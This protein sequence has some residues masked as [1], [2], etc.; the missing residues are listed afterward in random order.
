MPRE[1][2][3]R[4]LLALMLF[5]NSRRVA[6]FSTSGELLTLEQQ[7]RSLWITDDVDRA[8]AILASASERGPYVVQ[9]ALAESHALA[10]S[11][12]AT[13]WSRIV[14]LYDELLTLSPSPVAWFNRAIAVGMCDGPEAGLMLLDEL[15]KDLDGFRLVPAARADLLRRAGRMTEAIAQYRLAAQAAPKQPYYQVSVA[16]LLLAADRPQEAVAEYRAIAQK[17]PKDAS[18]QVGL[19]GALEKAG[20]KE[21]AMAAWKR[22]GELNP[23]DTIAARN[24]A[25]LQDES[26]KT[27]DAV[28]TLTAAYEKRPGDAAIGADLIRLAEKANQLDGAIATLNRLA[29]KG[30]ETPNLYTQLVNAYTRKDMAAAGTVAPTDPADPNAATA[31]KAASGLEVMK[32][33]MR[34]FPKNEGIARAVALYASSRNQWADAVTASRHLVELRPTD[35]FARRQLADAQASAGDI[36][37]AEETYSD[38]IK[39]DPTSTDARFQL[40]RLFEREN[41]IMAA[42]AQY[43]AIQQR[44]PNNAAAKEALERL[45]PPVGAAMTSPEPTAPAPVAPT[46]ATPAPATPVPP[47]VPAVPQDFV[48]N[49]L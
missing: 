22:A 38:V 26:G 13:D 23:L 40:A 2:E 47:V 49:I 11:P 31:P 18:V 21:G 27:A 39:A 36:K 42:R 1:S 34:R 25:R 33:Y 32:D 24:I 44:D 12:M 30:P 7:D 5:Q 17:N 46:P 37:G 6:R 43:E 14:A 29:E 3:A 20:N 10:P 48:F 15:P 41:E 16:R 45:K 9:A 8:R 28:T 4:G 35:N 19:A